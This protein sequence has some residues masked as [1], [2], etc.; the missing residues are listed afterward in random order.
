[1]FATVF[2]L[3]LMSFSIYFCGGALLIMM[4]Q[5]TRSESLFYYLSIEDHV[6]EDHLLRLIDRHIDFAFVRETL[7][8]S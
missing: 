2:S 5:N 6:P 3:T 8:A 4:G 1:V 7:Q